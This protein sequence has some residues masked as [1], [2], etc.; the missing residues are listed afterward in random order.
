MDV[1]SEI[2]KWL[3]ESEILPVTME[4]LGIA[5]KLAEVIGISFGIVVL[6][7][8]LGC[9]FGLKLAR[10]WAFLSA[11][12]VGAG[13]AFAISMQITADIRLS[14]MIGLGA[15]IVLAI[16]FAV[17]KRAGMFLTAWVM[18]SFLSIYWIQPKELMWLLVCTGIGLVFAFFTIKWYLPILILLTSVFGAVCISRGGA[19][20]LGNAGV[21]LENWM[22]ML[23]IVVLAV[24]GILVQFLMESGKRKKLHLKKAAEIREQNSTENEVDKAR[25]LL[26]EAFEEEE[27][28]EQ[29]EE[30]LDEE[31]EELEENPEEIVILEDEEDEFLDDDEEESEFWDE[32]DD[33]IQVVEIDLDDEFEE[34]E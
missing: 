28:K 2:G 12:A 11:F 14:G 22:L 13:T 27:P 4:R 24:L 19:V 32:E 31:D 18:G 29:S 3:Q 16:L 17:L 25:A 23:A 5:D 20:L 6:L 1:I 33:D 10:F 15:G 26:E 30:F 21:K 34:E 7:G 8:I 9:F